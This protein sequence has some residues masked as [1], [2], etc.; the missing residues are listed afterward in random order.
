M[1]SSAS[2][3][4]LWAAPESYRRRTFPGYCRA[5]SCSYLPADRPCPRCG[6]AAGTARRS[7]VSKS[8]LFV[9]LAVLVAGVIA[10]D[11]SR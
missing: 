5:C 4:T 3:P 2:L 11:A 1:A 7:A 8:V 9:G 10:L 6:Q